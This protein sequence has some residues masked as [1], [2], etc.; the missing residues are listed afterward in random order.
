MQVGVENAET[1]IKVAEVRQR[2]ENPKAYSM[3]ENG[4]HDGFATNFNAATTMTVSG[5]VSGSLATVAPSFNTD[6][7]LANITATLAGLTA[8]DWFLDDCEVVQG[9][10]PTF[11]G[12]TGNYSSHPDI[13]SV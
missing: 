2:W 11:K 10:A 5:E 3:D 7:A 6:V 1:G 13:T 9:R 8:G 12:F 4:T